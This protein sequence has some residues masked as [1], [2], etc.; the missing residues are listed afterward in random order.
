M[1]IVSRLEAIATILMFRIPFITGQYHAT[2]SLTDK[3]RMPSPQTPLPERARGFENLQLFLAPLLLLWEKGLGDEGK[4]FVSQ[5]VPLERSPLKNQT[6]R[7]FRPHIVMQHL[8]E[9][10]VDMNIEP[11]SPN[12]PNRQSRKSLELRHRLNDVVEVG[13]SGGGIFDAQ[14]C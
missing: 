2:G 13:S 12:I 11:A 7:S 4:R 9:R 14:Q 1:T 10:G 5:S 8:M 3:T 6:P